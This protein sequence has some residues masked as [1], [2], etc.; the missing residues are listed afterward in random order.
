VQRRSKN[1]TTGQ[2]RLSDIKLTAGPTVGLNNS[3]TQCTQDVKISVN[4]WMGTRS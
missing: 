3:Y 4:A 2:K 1:R